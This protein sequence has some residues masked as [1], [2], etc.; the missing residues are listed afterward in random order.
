VRNDAN[1]SRGLHGWI[2]P[3]DLLDVLEMDTAAANQKLGESSFDML[4][5]ANGLSL[6]P[7][8]VEAIMNAEA[9]V[10]G[11]GKSAVL[12]MA[13]G[14]GKTRIVPGMIHRFLKSGRFK[15]IL[16]LVGQTGS[17]ELTPDVFKDVIIENY[18]TLDRIHGIH[19]V[20]EDDIGRNARI[21]ISTVQRMYD[22]IYMGDGEMAPTVADYDLIIAD[23]A[24]NGLTPNHEPD[25]EEFGFDLIK[26]LD[27]FDAV[28]IVLTAD[29]TRCSA[30]TFGKPVFVYS[31][32][33]A[34]TEGYL[35][36]HTAQ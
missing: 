22:R 5:D 20:G 12:E 33:R 17:I 35:T 14:T 29:A 32:K 8:Q 15:R 2:G 10:T 4:R 6:R 21:H 25:N 36:D 7:Y 23:E 34:V 11:G 9:V 1:A 19:E 26:A 13:D 18:M 31:R 28:K 3:R 30:K 16:L 24:L 27:Y